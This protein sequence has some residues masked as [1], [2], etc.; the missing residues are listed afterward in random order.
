MECDER[1]VHAVDNIAEEKQMNRQQR[2][3]NALKQMNSTSTDAV[4]VWLEVIAPD[5]IKFEDFRQWM[6]TLRQIP[7]EMI[8][9]MA[10]CTSM[11]I[12]DAFTACCPD[13]VSAQEFQQLAAKPLVTKPTKTATDDDAT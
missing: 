9:Q 2:I 13:H 3:D 8:P 7:A 11:E 12:A 1:P 4:S 6:L 5:Q 10:D